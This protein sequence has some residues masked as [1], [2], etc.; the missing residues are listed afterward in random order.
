MMKDLE[1]VD[2]TPEVEGNRDS[3]S[4]WWVRFSPMT[5][6]ENRRFLKAVNMKMGSENSTNKAIEVLEQ[7]FT[8][9]VV[10]VHG[11]EDIRGK[12]INP[13]A[14]LLENGEKGKIDDVYEALT[15]AIKLK[16]G[17]KKK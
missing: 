16:R 13:G 2:Y 7:I 14:E 11:L 8:K 1:L 5:A 17:L 10:E 9:R 4:P 15:K 12:P 6:G 3:E